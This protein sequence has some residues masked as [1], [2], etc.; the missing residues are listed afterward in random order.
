MADSKAVEEGASSLANN[1]Q[2]M[3][4]QSDLSAAL[5]AFDRAQD[6]AVSR[7]DSGSSCSVLRSFYRS[8]VD[9]ADS[10]ARQTSTRCLLAVS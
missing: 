5:V 4:L 2:Y 9:T 3:A 8:C 7:L 10:F 6:W 1:K